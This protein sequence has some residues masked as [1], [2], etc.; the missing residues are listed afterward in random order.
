MNKN[1]SET[2]IQNN[3]S[4]EL[5]LNCYF[6]N[7]IAVELNEVI[8]FWELQEMLYTDVEVSRKYSY[9]LT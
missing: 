9:K 8:D 2:R 3:V 7:S 4:F 1:V 5:L 6:K